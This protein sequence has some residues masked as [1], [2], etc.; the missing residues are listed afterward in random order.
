[1]TQTPIQVKGTLHPK[2]KILSSFTHPRDFLLRRTEKIKATDF[3][4]EDNKY[5]M[6]HRRQKRLREIIFGWSIPLKLALEQRSEVFLRDVFVVEDKGMLCVALLAV[7][8]GHAD[9]L[10]PRAEVSADGHGFV[11][12]HRAAFFRQGPHPLLWGQTH[13]G[14]VQH[15]ADVL[16]LDLRRYRQNTI[17]D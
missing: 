17:S 7:H 14:V 11:H 8:V 4:Y 13:V 5:F 15:C 12:V 16:R 2:I 3:H 10:H 9:H 6:S 1:M